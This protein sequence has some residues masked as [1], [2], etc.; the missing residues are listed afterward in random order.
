MQKTLLLT[1]GLPRAGKSTWARQMA[2][3]YNCPIV[4]PDSVRLAIHGQRFLLSAEGYVWACVNTMVKAL[5]LAGHDLLILDATNVTRKRR[6]TWESADWGTLYVLL[7]TSRAECIQ[8]AVES[9]D[10]EIIPVIERMALER[11]LEF[12]EPWDVVLDPTLLLQSGAAL[13]DILERHHAAR[14]HRCGVRTQGAED[15]VSA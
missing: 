3:R 8:R 11:D 7:K 2:E 1:V 15:P 14:R 13:P 4:N 10:A 6:S 5:F 12:P 9:N